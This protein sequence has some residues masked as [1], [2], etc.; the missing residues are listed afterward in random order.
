MAEQLKQNNNFLFITITKRL[1]WHNTLSICDI[2]T[3]TYVTTQVRLSVS[4]KI[5]KIMG[6]NTIADDRLKKK[7]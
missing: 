1:E 3:I 5:D 4:L 6:S 7:R 2:N